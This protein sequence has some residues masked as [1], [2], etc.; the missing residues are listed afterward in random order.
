MLNIKTLKNKN[1]GKPILFFYK[2]VFYFV[3]SKISSMFFEKY[4]LKK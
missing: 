4:K 2:K 1:I 3:F